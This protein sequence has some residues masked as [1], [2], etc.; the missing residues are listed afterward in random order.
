VEE[1]VKTIL[2]SIA[3]GSLLAALTLGASSS[4]LADGPTFTTIDFPGSIATQVWGTNSSG[5]I[6]GLYV[7]SDKATHGF[8][9]SRG[10]FISI[11]YPGAAFTEVWGIGPR[12]EILGDY[13]DTLT[14]SG[15]HHG[16]VLSTDGVFSVVDFPGAVSSFALGMNSHGDILGSHLFADNVNRNFVMSGSQFP[17]SGQFTQLE[18]V[19]GAPV[20]VAIAILGSEVVGGFMGADKVAHGLLISEGHFTTIDYPAAGVT[21]TNVAAIDS[22]GEMGGRYTLN[23]VNHGYLL[24]GG[25]FHSFDYPGATFTMVTAIAPNGDLL[26]RYRDANNVFHGFR[27][28]GFGLA[29][30]SSGS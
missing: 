6:V 15:S 8:L 13:S 23:G 17:N 4:L 3:A 21:F 26:G 10:Q 28:T 19:P 24:S 18:D 22:R 7:S 2:T 25:Q 20:T 27:L 5:D 16:F 14:G 29:C 9:L 30:V 12:G 11:D 1:Q